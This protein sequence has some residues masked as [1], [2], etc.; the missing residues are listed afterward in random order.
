MHEPYIDFSYCLVYGL[1]VPSELASSHY[2]WVGFILWELIYPL[3]T[4]WWKSLWIPSCTPLSLILYWIQISSWTLTWKIL[5]PFFFKLWRSEIC[6]LSFAQFNYVHPRF[7]H[8][9]S[10]FRAYYKFFSLKLDTMTLFK[11]LQSH[12]A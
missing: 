1:S 3:L 10:S 6:F 2:L 5:S 4:I 12:H 9:I 8:A 11:S 7:D